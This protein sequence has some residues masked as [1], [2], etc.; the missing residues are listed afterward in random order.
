MS[1]PFLGE[2]FALASAFCYGFSAVAIN[3]NAENGHS[4][5]GAYLSILLT[6]VMAGAL[7]LFFGSALPAA[8]RA[9]WTG[10]GFFVLAGVLANI[11]GRVFMF[12]AVELVG[13]IEIG[14]LRRLIPVF[15]ATLAIIFLDERIT[16]SVSV[17]FLL[18]FLGIAAVVVG[19]RRTRVV[20][21]GTGGTGHTGRQMMERATDD[22]QKG[23]VLGAV[24]SASY[25]GAYVS[26]K[27]ALA[28]VPD[29]LLGTLIGAITGLVCGSII[30]PLS[31]R[32]RTNH[33]PLFQRPA[34]WQVV[35]AASVSFGQIFQFFALN[36]TTVTAVAIIGSVEMFIAAWLSAVLLKSE[37]KPGLVFAVASVLA[38]TGTAVITLGQGNGPI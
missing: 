2:I 37:K 10:L 19:G 34:P 38:M 7:W 22:V 3:K 26:R 35:A 31:R 23:R 15:A 25:G 8:D 14:I 5:N 20:T 32:S 1:I 24:S 27:F 30:V 36:H 28:V 12:K 16:T 11:S 21:G 6:A 4:N 13:A 17:G 33:L 9:V 18:V 29:P